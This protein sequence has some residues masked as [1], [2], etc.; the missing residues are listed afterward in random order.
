MIDI[1]DNQ[2]L[3]N[4]CFLNNMVDVNTY[5]HISAKNLP[6]FYFVYRW[7]RFVFVLLRIICVIKHYQLII[8]KL[9]Y[10]SWI[11][12]IWYKVGYLILKRKR[13]TN[14][15]LHNLWGW[16]FM[17]ETY[18]NSNFGRI[19][20]WREKERRYEIKNKNR[21]LIYYVLT[22]RIKLH[23]TSFIISWKDTKQKIS[24]SFIFVHSWINFI[25]L[26]I[27]TRSSVCILEW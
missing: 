4:L 5:Y 22:S 20:N 3:L 7:L 12:F 9:N 8:P 6:S 1:S 23:M 10:F 19:I 11:F 17:I 26:W 14:H 16:F 21:L 15:S 18:E 27:K 24:F 13:G 2:R 25:L